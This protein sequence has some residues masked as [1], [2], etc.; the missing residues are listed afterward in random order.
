MSG[1]ETI[2]GQDAQRLADRRPAHAELCQQLHLGRNRPATLPLPRLDPLAQHA[3][4]LQVTRDRGMV[5]DRGRGRHLYRSQY[6]A[7]AGV[8][9][10]VLT[11]DQKRRSYAEI[12]TNLYIWLKAGW[13]FGA[14]ITAC[15]L[16]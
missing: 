14:A 15:I 3:L 7:G 5:G 1:D 10:A 12:V 4:D 8:S 2:P 9:T 16:S 11:T 6:I 13:G